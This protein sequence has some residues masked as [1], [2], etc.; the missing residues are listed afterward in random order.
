MFLII[1]RVCQRRIREGVLKL[2]ILYL[3]CELS[4]QTFD[5]AINNGVLSAFLVLN[6]IRVLHA[7]MLLAV[8]KKF[9]NERKEAVDDASIELLLVKSGEIL[10]SSM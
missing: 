7:R 10:P 6:I 9:Q 8:V 1:S 5:E 2:C 4:Y 3:N